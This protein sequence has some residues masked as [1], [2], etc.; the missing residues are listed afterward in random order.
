MAWHTVYCRCGVCG[1]FGH[2]SKSCP[3]RNT[4]VT[5]SAQLLPKRLNPARASP[6]PASLAS[7]QSDARSTAQGEGKLAKQDQVE[8]AEEAAGP[9]QQVEAELLEPPASEA[10]GAAT[11][12]PARAKQKQQLVDTQLTSSEDSY[13]DAAAAPA[14]EKAESHKAS[15]QHDEQLQMEASSA[16]DGEVAAGALQDQDQKSAEQ[17]AADRA[18]VRAKHRS[19]SASKQLDAPDGAAAN[20]PEESSSTSDGSNQ[21]QP[22]S[23]GQAGSQAVEVSHTQTDAADV[24]GL[25]QPQGNGKQAVVLSASSHAMESTAASEAGALPADEY[26]AAGP[27]S[28]SSAD[29][30]R[31]WL[32]P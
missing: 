26:S 4:S 19:Q 21:G 5:M 2:Y 15:S 20:T 24:G 31:T 11:R 17:A 1:E 18:P 27:D 23:Q 13:D 14:L 3:K 12:P 32:C 8:E 10:L 22:L 28:D 16:Q 9:A 30:V 7:S 25:R 29:E 6:R